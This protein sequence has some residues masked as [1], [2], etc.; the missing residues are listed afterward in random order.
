[1]LG[2]TQ[3]WPLT[4]SS[5]IEHG[6]A[7]YGDTEVVSRS[8]EG[9]LHRYDYRTAEQRARRLAKALHMHGLSAGEIV[10]SLAWTTHRLFELFYA[11]PGLGAVLHTANP[12]LAPEQIAYT[13]NHAGYRYLF[14]DL[15]C[16]SVAEAIAPSLT[17]VVHFVVM[18][19][20][21][22]MPSTSSLK[23]LLCYE[24]LIA[25]ADDNFVWPVL[26]ER[27]ASTLCYTSGTTG[28]PK[29][30]LYSH[31]GSVLNSMAITSGSGWSLGPTDAVLSVAAFFHCNGW[32]APYVGPMVG[33]K[34]VLPGRALDAASLHELIVTEGVT[35]ATGVPTIW[36]SVLE[37]LASTGGDLGRLD[38]IVCGGTTP[39]PAMVQRLRR[40]Y[41]VRTIHAWG[42]TETT[43]ASTA[44]Q[45]PPE[46][47]E[48][49]EQEILRSQGRPIYGSAIRVVDTTG[50]VLPRDGASVGH[51][52]IR[53]HWIASAYFR[54]DDPDLLDDAGWMNTGDVAVI[55]PDG[56]M[57]I[58]DRSKDVIK[59]G[60]EWISSVELE[61]AAL[62][63]PDVAEAAVIG[64]E[65]P[66]WQERPLL[67]VVPRPGAEIAPGALRRW[68]ADRVAKWWLPDAVLVVEELPRTA[69]GKVRKNVLRE[70]YASCLLPGKNCVSVSRRD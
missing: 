31:R 7:N 50:E 19:D 61:N 56:A 22:H 1:M 42:M 4:T 3:F 29:G 59:S 53:G 39:P 40:D 63:H 38:R 64:V 21:A 20:A 33:A 48:A 49:Q 15:D 13:I 60:G 43:H 46:A 65:H 68:M 8:A 36:L 18:T 11:V 27:R 25:G 55:R 16:L 6:A 58:T 44:I 34:L 24:D 30:V 54:R 70:Q 10:G 26:D 17:N 35:I 66:K 67:L 14:V 5:I 12:R 51:L 69:T 9:G 37:H 52:Q 45:A 32:G 62:A 47:S 2:L 41:G 23:N 57:Q 28:D